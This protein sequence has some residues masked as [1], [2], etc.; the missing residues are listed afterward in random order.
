MSLRAFRLAV[1]AAAAVLAAGLAAGHVRRD[2]REDRARTLTL[3][4]EAAGLVREAMATG[5]DPVTAAA[6]AARRLDVRVRVALG[7]AAPGALLDSMRRDE[8]A[9]AITSGAVA[10]LKD[11]DDWDVIGV[12]S[13]EPAPPAH[14]P[15]PARATMLVPVLLLALAATWLWR[16]AGRT[17]DR[18]RREILTAWSFL[19]APL[20]HL[21]VFSFGPVAVTF[22]LALHRWDLLT[23][24]R[25]YIGLANFRSVAGDP[26]FRTTLWN[27]ALYVSYVPVTMVLAFVLALWL[28]RGRRGEALLRA[29]V[30][31][32]YVTSAVAI[33]LVWQWMFNPDVGLVNRALALVGIAAL[34][35]LGSPRTALLAIIIVTVWTQVGYQM[36]VFLAGL[37][38]IP[39]S[40]LDAARVDGAGPWQRLRHVVIPLLRPVI[41]FVLVT[42]IIAGF[43]VFT[44]VYLMTEGGP[45]HS[46]DVV[47]YRIYQVA[48][49][50]LR[51]GEASA[52]AV[53]LFLILLAL[54]AVQF[55]LLGRRVEPA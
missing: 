33:A 53:V 36:V 41:L 40:Y 50:F 7:A 9:R 18:R 48:W 6:A 30:F 5:R 32:P 28:N 1:V 14:A 15:L 47:V 11:A 34:D 13:V 31:L 20:L 21:S 2:A 3:A 52:M 8:A 19:G 22:W 49:E 24:D 16:W 38:A 55:R 17:G 27:T 46:T 37:Q 29:V 42:G 39:P 45:L 43:Q 54:T 35:W 10:P 44:L 26:L 51:F 25:P 12:V 23:S 4:R